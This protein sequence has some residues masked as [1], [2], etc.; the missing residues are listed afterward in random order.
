M[1][2][3]IYT[4]DLVEENRH[5]MP[6]RMVLEIGQAA[7]G[8]G[9][10]TKV[11]SGR[12]HPTGKRWA[13]G[14][15]PVEEIEKPYSNGPMDSFQRVIHQEGFDV[16]FW[17]VAWCNARRQGDLLRRTSIPIVWYVPGAC[18]LP[19]R[20]VRA[21][22]DLGLRSAFPFLLQ[23]LYP[24][25]YL[26]KRLQSRATS[27]MITVSLFNRSAVCR[28]GWPAEDVFV[29]PPGKPV[30]PASGNGEEPTVFNATRGRLGGR[31][32]YLYL[33]PPERI[34]GIRQLLEAFDLLASR[35][36]DVCLVCLFRSDPETDNAPVRRIVEDR[37]HAERIFCV[38]ESVVRVDLDAFLEACHA[39]VL[40]F[41]LVPSEIPL[42][43][44]EAAGHHKPVI[45]TGP[46]GT[47]EFAGEFGLAVP[48]GHGKA[49][50][51]AMLRLLDDKQLHADKCG[52]AQRMYAAHPT[53]D[54]VAQSWLSIAAQAIQR[55]T[56]ADPASV[57]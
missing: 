17:P 6:W 10:Q 2:M 50:A 46:G 15:C 19:R 16:L 54:D 53:W 20:A 7:C 55:A 52:A 25:K 24:K 43:I 29:V 39:V 12:R 13:Y 33:G 34:R 51:E 47:A 35:R 28:A 48:S 5:L 57:S 32:F 26:V 14:S 42:A 27:L 38:W 41:L 1:R 37:S 44:I 56:Q 9:H 40:P 21:I 45:T 11:L 36:A 30:N 23:S 22:P 31:P 3:A 18:Y 49:L 4:S 8:A